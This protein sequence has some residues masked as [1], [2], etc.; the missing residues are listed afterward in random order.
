M[1]AAVPV[2]FI[3]SYE[4]FTRSPKSILRERRLPFFVPASVHGCCPIG[5]KQSCRCNP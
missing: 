4:F 5:N 3:V 2:Q 1:G